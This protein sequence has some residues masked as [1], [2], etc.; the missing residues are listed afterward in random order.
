[1]SGAPTTAA[2][3]AALLLTGLGFGTPSLTFCGVALELLAATAVAW[4]EL[5]RPRALIREGGPSRVIEAEPFGLKVRSEGARV[6]PPGGTLRD[7]LLEEPVRVG[8][9]WRGVH[10]GTVALS[11]RGRRPLRPARLEIHDPLRLW[12][13]ALES[14]EPGELLI[15]PRIHPVIVDGRGA[16]GSRLGMRAGAAVGAGSGADAHAIELEV[17]GLRAYRE[18]SP[19]SRIHWPAVAR[20]GELVERRLVAGADSAPLVALDSSRPAGAAELD[21]AVRAAAS[22]CI[23]LAARGGCAALLPGD[24]RPTEVEPEL[25]GW[26]HLHARFALVEPAPPPVLS[27]APRGGAVFWVTARARPALPAPLRA[28]GPAGRYLVAPAGARGGRPSFA[29]G[30]CEG[31]SFAKG[32]RPPREAAA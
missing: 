27:G 29:V 12:V 15:L 1:M 32:A 23:H 16:G 7:S 14:H 19:A 8:P 20:T 26:P 9:G 18:G 31:F 3:G 2:L 17:D 5:A 11:G 10:E 21:A 30:G 25:R 4:V 28:A 22:L 24:R 6:R 13:R